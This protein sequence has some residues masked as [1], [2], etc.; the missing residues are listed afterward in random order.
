MQVSDAMTRDVLMVQPNQN[1][2]EAAK[3]MADSDCGVLPVA[4]NA[5]ISRHDY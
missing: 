5:K 1:I 4:E 2:A 3:M